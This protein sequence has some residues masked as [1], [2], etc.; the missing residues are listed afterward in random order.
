MS[1]LSETQEKINS[2]STNAPFFSPL[3]MFENS[4]PV[5]PYCTDDLGVLFIRPKLEAIKRRYIQPNSPWDLKWLLYDI[6]SPTGTLD[7]EDVHAP[8]PNIVVTNPENGHAHLF[9]GLTVPVFKQPEAH[10]KPLRYAASVDVAL[11]KLLNADEG[12]AGLI[13]KNPLNAF[14]IVQERE[15]APYDLPELADW[16]DLAP[17]ADRRKYLPAIGLGRNCTLFDA[18]RHWAYKARGKGGY[19]N[20]D[21]FIYVVTEYVAAR[22]V[23]F[24]VPLPP[25]EVKAIGKSVGRWTWRNMSEEGKRAWHSR[26]GKAG[27][28]KSIVVRQEKSQERAQEIRAY[29]AEHPE[30]GTRAIGEIFSVSFMTVARALV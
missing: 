14:W 19:F 4:L 10:A 17:Y 11:T 2:L 12:Y 8:P 26:K 9:Y 18:T 3:Q 23:E 6:D 22:N 16:L 21:F 28:K 15:P 30:A 24:P 25:S 13:A 27:N 5:R 1:T 29:K 20:E 7:W